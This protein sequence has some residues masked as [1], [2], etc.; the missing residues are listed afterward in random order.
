[1]SSEVGLVL[2]LM[3]MSGYQTRNQALA[4]IFMTSETQICVYFNA[5]VK[6]LFHRFE[7][8]VR[9]TGNELLRWSKCAPTFNKAIEERIKWRDPSFPISSDDS[10]VWGF[11]GGCLVPISRPGGQN[12]IQMSVYS[13]HKKAYGLNYMVINA[14]NGLIISFRGPYTGRHNDN[15]AVQ[16]FT[17]SNVFSNRVKN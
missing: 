6:D 3:K 7:F 13:G 2:V 12:S 16:K 10:N 14:P 8:L 17:S 1:M 11:V 9:D 4:W 5:V 15:F